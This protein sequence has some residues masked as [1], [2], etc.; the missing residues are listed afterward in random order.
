[1]LRCWRNFARNFKHQDAIDYNLLHS[2]AMSDFQYCGECLIGNSKLLCQTIGSVG[3]V[4][5]RLRHSDCEQLM[6]DYSRNRFVA[7]LY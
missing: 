5:Y 7:I 3:L 6:R 2:R 1:M 4:L